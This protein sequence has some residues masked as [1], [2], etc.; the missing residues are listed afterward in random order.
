[1]AIAT[2]TCS[3]LGNKECTTGTNLQSNLGTVHVKICFLKSSV[4]VSNNNFLLAMFKTVFTDRKI[5]IVSVCFV[6]WLNNI[7]Q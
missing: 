7:S 6:T 2:C 4:F 5:D 3:G 1:M